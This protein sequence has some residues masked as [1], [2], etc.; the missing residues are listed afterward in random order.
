MKLVIIEGEGK[1]ET[2]LKYLKK[3]DGDYTVMASKGHVRDLPVKTLAINVNNNFE[4]KYVVMDDKKDIV[5]EL[6][7]KAAKADQILLATDPDRE[8]EAISWHLAH[9][10]EIPEDKKCRIEFN[11]IS[12]KAVAAALT[13]PRVIDRSLVDAQQ[14][15]RVLDRLVGYKLSPVL[16][17]KI[18]SNLSAGRVQSVALRLVVDREREIL[19]FK[20]EEYWVLT[21]F[22]NKNN[23]SFKAVLSK[24]KD[25]TV[26]VGAKAQ[27]DKVLSELKSADGYT[28]RS[29][30]KG[31]TKSHAPA[32]FITST[33]QQD[34]LNKL[35]FSLKQT[36]QL[37]QMLYEGIDLPGEGK[38][39]LVTYIRT[40]STRVSVDAQNEALD[41]IGKK[42]GKRYVPDKP[43]FYKSRKG[44]QDAHEAIRPISITR[45]P[46]SIK[47]LSNRNAFRLYKL[48]YD[49]FLA[50]QM[51]EAEFNTVSV[52][53]N[54]ADYTFKASGR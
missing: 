28:V 27:M 29:I 30:K 40:D 21:A 12:Q 7:A 44:A 39:A 31:I 51:S 1:R 24:Y 22:L 14:A 18:Q 25:K 2:I 35:G 4:P 5:R 48:V 54:A 33:L 32:P 6:K 43:N 53:I 9:I 37:A 15:R 42:F 52:E 19:G 8:G 34:A 10:L 36:T 3:I 41:Y 47:N 17:K 20:P 11:E 46:E 45:T 16:C 38:V 49:R 13:A 26:K 23:I 50:S